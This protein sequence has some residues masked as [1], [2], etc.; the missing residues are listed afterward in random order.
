MRPPEAD[1]PGSIEYNNRLWKRTRNERIILQTQ[2]QKER[3]AKGS[4]DALQAQ[5]T[6]RG[7]VSSLL[8]H[9]FENHLIAVGVD[10]SIKYC[11]AFMR[12]SDTNK[13]QCMG[14]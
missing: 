8:F 1:E 11:S 13:S 14:S 4:W 7:H 2:P 9:Q 5:M 10:N 6:N 12:R 3:G